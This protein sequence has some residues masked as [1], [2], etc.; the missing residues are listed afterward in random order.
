MAGV[1]FLYDKDSDGIGITDDNCPTIANADQADVDDDGERDLCDADIDG[2]GIYNG[3]A[4]DQSHGRG[5]VTNVFNVANGDPGAI[6]LAQT[7]SVDISGNLARVSLPVSCSSGN[8][9]LSIRTL[10]GADPGTSSIDGVTIPNPPTNN[11]GFVDFKL[12]D[13]AVAAGDNLAIV[14]STNGS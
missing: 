1:S 9:Q 14:I 11:S 12:N 7:F 6:L 2:D 10:I 4:V 13:V 5:A 3:T 8:L